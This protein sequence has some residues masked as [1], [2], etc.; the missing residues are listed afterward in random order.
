M[1][2]YVAHK[3]SGETFEKTNV[4]LISATQ[5]FDTSTPE[6]KFM[7]RMLTV[8][9]EFESGMISKRTI[10]GLRAIKN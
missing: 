10:D 9:A 7:L 8:L 5:D 2:I 4:K 6:G 1:R 3:L